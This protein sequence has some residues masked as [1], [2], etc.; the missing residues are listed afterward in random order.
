MSKVNARKTSCVNE[1]ISLKIKGNF[2]VEGKFPRQ[3]VKGPAYTVKM[4]Y[5]LPH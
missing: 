1:T 3:T 5:T 2:N 4:G